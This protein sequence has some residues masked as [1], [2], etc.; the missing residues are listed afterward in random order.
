MTENTI[1]YVLIKLVVQRKQ[2]DIVLEAALKAGAPG[3][4]YYY[5]R[6]TGVREKLGI[7]ARLIEA[8]KMIIEI[9]E[10]E[11]RANKLLDAII[12]TTNINLPGKGFCTITPVLR[13][14]GFLGS[15]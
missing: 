13:V 3:I 12:K 10:R 15:K 9:V 5:A 6:G 8:E 4:T 11:E 14:E 7:L 1:K 2:G